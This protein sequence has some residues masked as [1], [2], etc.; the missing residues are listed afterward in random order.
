MLKEQLISELDRIYTF[1]SNT[2]ECLSEEDSEFTPADGTYT[3]AQHIAHTAQSIDWFIEGA[4]INEQ[5]DMNFEKHIAD[6]KQTTSLT[7]AKEWLQKSIE[8]AKSIL[9]SN[10]DGELL[11][12]LPEGPVMGGAPRMAVIGG[13]ADHTAHHRGA[14]AVYA[15]LL[16][17]V[18]KMPYS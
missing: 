9:E 2:I 12:P 13:L 11:S 1:F 15:R 5:F 8:K 18:P 17:K 4:F 10:S 6:I 16:G 3:T 14:L 7:A